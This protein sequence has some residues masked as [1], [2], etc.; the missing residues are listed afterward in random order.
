[1]HQYRGR[2]LRFA[3]EAVQVRLCYFQTMYDL[4]YLA[5]LSDSTDCDFQLGRENGGG[6]MI[7][8]RRL[9]TWEVLID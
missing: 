3:L 4:I 5:F 7:C 2:F 9:W 1:M 6:P 8:F